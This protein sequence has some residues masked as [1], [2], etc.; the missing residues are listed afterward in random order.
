[1][2]AVF[3]WLARVWAEIRSRVVVTERRPL[4]VWL[5]PLVSTPVL[6]ALLTLIERQIVP[7]FARPQHLALDLGLQLAL[8]FL[9]L[10]FSRRVA[11]FVVLQL[12][13]MAFIYLG[14]ALKLAYF[15][16]PLRTEDAAASLDLIRILPARY[17]VLLVGAAVAVVMLAVLNF[18]VRPTVSAIAGAGLAMAAVAF[19]VAPGALV[20]R[21]DAFFKVSPWD[22]AENLRLLGSTAFTLR[23][24][25]LYRASRPTVPSR[26]EVSAVLGQ[27]QMSLPAPLLP[28]GRRN[29]YVILAESFWDPT[30]LGARLSADPIDPQLRAL[31]QAG[32]DAVA[33]S[34]VTAGQTAEVELEL[35][36]GMPAVGG[37]VKFETTLRNDV[38]CLPRLLR[39]QG[40][41]AV[42]MH[43]NFP[44]F[45]NRR[46]A[47]SHLGFE[48]FVSRG[49]FELD[50][51][52]G[53]CLS[54]TSLLRQVRAHIEEGRNGRPVFAFIVTYTGHWPYVLAPTRPPTVKAESAVPQLEAYASSVYYSSR[55][56]LA[57]IEELRSTDPEALVLLLGDH[58][59]FLGPGFAAYV[60]AG[61]VPAA[62]AAFDGSSFVSVLAT[63]LLLLDRGRAV[64]TG[65]RAMF[66]LAPVLLA[67]A[68]QAPPPWMRAFQPP[69]GLLVR[70]VNEGESVLGIGPTGEAEL[71]RPGSALWVCELVR[72][73]TAGCD[74]LVRDLLAGKQYALEAQGAPE[75][76]ARQSA[77]APGP[78]RV[79]RMRAGGT[80]PSASSP[81][82]TSAAALAL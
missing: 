25:A 41:Y 13:V 51:M 50:D 68:G 23:E 61:L 76:A 44:A 38:P 72:G 6:Y 64:T 82:A 45:W 7:Q 36:C 73:W 79:V 52:N 24:L 78:G 69:P 47:Y 42:A 3:H 8:A 63:P 46:R 32:G 10:A 14:N 17:M 77:L 27:R 11:P 60:E 33:L 71:C 56:Y 12:L 40:Y 31:L 43:P 20:T 37:G 55:E 9:L 4:G 29:V 81:E 67:G 39:D 21:F 54:D 65:D 2:S 48:R 62:L 28:G 74:V 22:R 70:P 80:S 53:D 66:E 35:L 59:P 5:V 34:P 15:G 75:T 16:S 57:F 19:V 1:M 18:G 26:G 49:D 30:V 58:P